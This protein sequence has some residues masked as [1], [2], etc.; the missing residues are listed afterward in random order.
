MNRSE[1]TTVV[2]VSHC[3]CRRA[4]PP[5]FVD[6]CPQQ[7][8]SGKG[9]CQ[10]SY[11]CQ[12]TLTQHGSAPWLEHIITVVQARQQRS[13]DLEAN[14]AARSF[15]VIVVAKKYP[16]R[17][18]NTDS[19]SSSAVLKDFQIKEMAGERAKCPSKESSKA[20]RK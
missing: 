12:A 14:F 10:H 15:V 18:S 9:R 16:K 11:C 2:F 3:E 6:A 19:P 8:R 17:E 7:Q 1:R 20:K 13:N 4:V 5:L